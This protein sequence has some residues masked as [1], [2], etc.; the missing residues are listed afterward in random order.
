MNSIKSSLICIIS[1]LVII[2]ILAAG[3]AAQ[4][5]DDEEGGISGTGNDINCELEKYKKHPS[6]MNK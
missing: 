1:M 3:C 4:R 6:C 2:S 5:Y